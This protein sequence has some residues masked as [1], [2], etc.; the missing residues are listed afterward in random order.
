[1]K[2]TCNFH[3]VLFLKFSV[4]PQAFGDGVLYLPPASLEGAWGESQP[5]TAP[6]TLVACCCSSIALGSQKQVSCGSGEGG[7]VSGSLAWPA[8]GRCWE[9]LEVAHEFCSHAV[10]GTHGPFLRR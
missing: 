3:F 1:M 4:H 9:R 6:P 8:T 10:P 2:P 5:L 7:Q